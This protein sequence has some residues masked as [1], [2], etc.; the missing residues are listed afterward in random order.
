[1]EGRVWRTSGLERRMGSFSTIQ[2]REVFLILS[3]VSRKR[4]LGHLSSEYEDGKETMETY[5]SSHFN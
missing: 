3:V 4:V 2:G 5:S 1:M